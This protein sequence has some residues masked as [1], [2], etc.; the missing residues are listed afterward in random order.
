MHSQFDFMILPYLVHAG[1]PHSTAGAVPFGLRGTVVGITQVALGADGPRTPPF[2]NGTRPDGSPAPPEVSFN[3]SVIN[4][5]VNAAAPAGAL[6]VGLSARE[7]AAAAQD[8]ARYRDVIEVVFDEP[9]LGGS[10]LH[11]RSGRR[12]RSC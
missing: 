5:T 9:F 8:G 10:S 1:I 7:A 11:G 3:W 12:I 2:L 4:G 6:A